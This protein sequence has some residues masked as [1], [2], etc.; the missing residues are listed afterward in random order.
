MGV[1]LCVHVC[2]FV[3]LCVWGGLCACVCMCMPVCV[4]AHGIVL[5][6]GEVKCLCVSL[7]GSFFPWGILDVP[8]LSGFNS[9]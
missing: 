2:D 1:R 4:C 9:V 6:L 7:F 3:P 8:L 5:V